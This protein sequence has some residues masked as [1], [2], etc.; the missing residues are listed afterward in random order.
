MLSAPLAIVIPTAEVSPVAMVAAASSSPSWAPG[1]ATGHF[2]PSAEGNQTAAS[3][4]RRAATL[5]KD[6]RSGRP[7]RGFNPCEH[8]DRGRWPVMARPGRGAAPVEGFGGRAPRRSPSHTRERCQRYETPRGVLR[9]IDRPL[10]DGVD[11]PVG[12]CRG[13]PGSSFVCGRPPA[14]QSGCGP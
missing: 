5:A 2:T 10:V 12:V 4:S 7:N 3:S 11:S 9:L 8:G 1:A 6:S 13:E 14:P